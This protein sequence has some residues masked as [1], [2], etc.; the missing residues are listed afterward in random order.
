MYHYLSF[1]VQ[2]AMYIIIMYI[3]SIQLSQD[4]I[5]LQGLHTRTV[6]SVLQVFVLLVFVTLHSIFRFLVT[7]LKKDKQTF[8]LVDFVSQ[9]QH[10]LSSESVSVTG[11]SVSAIRNELKKDFNLPDLNLRGGN[12][13]IFVFLDHNYIFT[14]ENVVSDITIPN[15][16][17]FFKKI[18][19]EYSQLFKLKAS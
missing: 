17:G 18:R 2:L 12:K 14:N 3:A 4:D 8:V 16:K 13:T 7:M 15:M 9:A 1:F 11:T 6:V 19:S 10:E 5:R